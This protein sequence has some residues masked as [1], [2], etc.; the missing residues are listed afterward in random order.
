MKCYLIGVLSYI[1][2]MT[3]EIEFFIALLYFIF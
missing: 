1:V 3:N 2:L